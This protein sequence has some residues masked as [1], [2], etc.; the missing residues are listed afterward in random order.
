MTKRI[1]AAE[2]LAKLQADPRWVAERAKEEKEFRRRG[3]ELQQ[4]EAPLVADVQSAGFEVESVWDLVNT[5]ASY[6]PAL[7]VLLEHLGRDYPPAIREGIARALATP[8]AR[9]ARSELIEAFVAEKNRR[10][11]DGLAVAV[12]ETSDIEDVGDLDDVLALLQNPEHGSSRILLLSVL[13]RLTG[14][15]QHDLLQELSTDPEL[16]REIH[17][18]EKRLQRRQRRSRK[19]RGGK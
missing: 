9:F 2:L 8:E 4:A 6:R 3:L 15:R 5:A 19:R 11:K 17:E 10:V 7:P 18:I 12:A 13:E 1:T 14:R 16:T